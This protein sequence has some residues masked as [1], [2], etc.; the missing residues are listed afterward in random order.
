[1]ARLCLRVALVGLAALS[2]A[3]GVERVIVNTDIGHQVDDV[4]ALSLLLKSEEV[5]VL[6]VVVSGTDGEQ[7]A[8]I[9]RHLLYL[10]GHDDIPVAAGGAAETDQ[11][12]VGPIYHFSE[13]FGRVPPSELDGPELFLEAISSAGGKV[14]VLS[15][16]PLTTVASALTADPAVREKI[17]SIIVSPGSAGEWEYFR[18]DPAGAA[19]VIAQV[20][21]FEIAVP[22]ISQKAAWGDIDLAGLDGLPV[23]RALREMAIYGDV[24]KGT[25]LIDTQ[26]AAYAIHRELLDVK[27]QIC[28]PEMIGLASGAF[29]KREVTVLH[30]FDARSYRQL[31]NDRLRDPRATVVACLNRV[32]AHN[33]DLT[34][35]LS[36]PLSDDLVA[37]RRLAREIRSQSRLRTETRESGMR[38]IHRL[39][40][41]LEI[42]REH[43]AGRKMSQRLSQASA[44]LGD[45]R[46]ALPAEY[47]N[48]GRFKGILGDR[49][50]VTLGLENRGP[51]DIPRARFTVFDWTLRNWKDESVIDLRS[52]AQ[53]FRSFE[54]PLPLGEEY[55]DFLRARV[56]LKWQFEAG[57]ATLP[58]EVWVEVMPPFVMRLPE[59]PREDLLTIGIT[60]NTTD[61]QQVLVRLEPLHGQWFISENEKTIKFPV[62]SLVDPTSIFAGGDGKTLKEEV[63]TFVT[64]SP[65]PGELNALKVIASNG[66]YQGSLE[67]VFPRPG[68]GV[69]WV[70]ESEGTPAQ[71]EQVENQWAI[72]TNPEAGRRHAYYRVVDPSLR[73]EK[74]ASV[75][76]EV[77]YYDAGEAEDRFVIE[78]D[79]E[80]P[81]P[82]GKRF[83]AS[84]TAAKPGEKGWHKHRF[85]L[86]QIS[87]PSGSSGR[88]DFRIWDAGDGREIIGRVTVSRARP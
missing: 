86:P 64:P 6:A 42:L 13:D 55:P 17:S 2:P 69:V 71:F 68:S 14:T 33:A 40:K 48:T 15:F 24:Q 52:G 76:I 67:V 46:I 77:D 11:V 74:E 1:M 70:P 30:G 81:E 59:P 87:L 32:Q 50:E 20:K 49:A 12:P 80:V 31:L 25:P 7:R 60:P 82:D 85:V 41:K 8:R 45:I 22:Q 43:H 3:W 84:V 39:L 57:W 27:Q 37:I 9:G 21:R 75:E 44:I 78:Y 34:P 38:A 10:L 47:R 5:E 53:Q 83:Q 18:R 4:V 23:G 35:A 28:S 58:Y 61:R 62:P 54:F 66:T 16:G 26:V 63:V 79:A 29:E 65:P 36:S 19:T 51:F 56:L 73:G 88:P 72:V